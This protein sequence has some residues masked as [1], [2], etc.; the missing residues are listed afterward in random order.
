MGNGCS[1]PWSP[2]DTHPTGPK[3]VPLGTATCISCKE[4]SPSR[5]VGDQHL[6]V[7]L[8][9]LAHLVIPIPQVEV[10]IKTLVRGSRVMI[11][12]CLPCVAYMWPSKKTI[13]SVLEM[14]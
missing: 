10:K 14:S 6:D 12:E 8:L 4:A 11:A 9:N 1:R 7:D 3:L 13:I 5:P 2:H